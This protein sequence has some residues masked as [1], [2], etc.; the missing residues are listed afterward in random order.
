MSYQY[1]CAEREKRRKVVGQAVKDYRHCFGDDGE[2][3]RM[4]LAMTGTMDKK[5]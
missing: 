5:S 3:E 4:I 1:V 2:W